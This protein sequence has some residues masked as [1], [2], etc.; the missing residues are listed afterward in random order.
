MGHRFGIVQFC[1]S[2]A[3]L[4][5]KPNAGIASIRAYWLGA[6]VATSFYFGS[7]ATVQ[8]RLSH[9]MKSPGMM[10]VNRFINPIG[11]ESPVFDFGV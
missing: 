9:S 4:P 5:C 10:R 3:G 8:P 11:P 7:A 2:A 6:H 1:E